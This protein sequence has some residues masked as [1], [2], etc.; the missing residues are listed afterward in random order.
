MTP[1]SKETLNDFQE[2]ARLKQVI[3]EMAA[4]MLEMAHKSHSKDATL[5][6]LMLIIEH[7]ISLLDVVNEAKGGEL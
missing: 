7:D 6:V 4:Q 2:V 1:N 5:K 3:V